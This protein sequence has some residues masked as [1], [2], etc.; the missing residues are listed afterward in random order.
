MNIN[1]EYSSSCPDIVDPAQVFGEDRYIGHDEPSLLFYPN[2]P[3]SDN[4][5]RYS[6]TLSRGRRWLVPLNRAGLQLRA[7][8][9]AVVRAGPV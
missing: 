3:G 9:R 4:R 7:Q 1:C 2:K 8:R 6:V 5:M